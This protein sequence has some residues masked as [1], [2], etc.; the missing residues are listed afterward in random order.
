[1]IHGEKKR[2]VRVCTCIQYTEREKEQVR[3]R[4]QG[5]KISIIGEI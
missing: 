3:M 1:M 2:Y 5:G 4:T